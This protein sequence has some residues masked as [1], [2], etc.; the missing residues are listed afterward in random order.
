MAN[1][2]LAKI[3]DIEA[4]Y[5]GAFKKVRAALGIT[6][7]GVQ[8]MDLP[9]NATGHPEHDHSNDGQEELYVTLRGGGEIEIDGERHPLSPEVLVRVGPGTKRKLL[10]GDEGARL[11]IIGGVPGSAYEVQQFT[12]LGE[13]DPAL[14]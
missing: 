1:F 13:A 9:P 12:E 5:R 6:S 10:P 11:L 8:V 4:I 14:D 2:E 7:F 3:D